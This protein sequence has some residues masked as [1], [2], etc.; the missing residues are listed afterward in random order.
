MNGFPWLT[1]AAIVLT[2]PSTPRLSKYTDSL[3][4]HWP[5]RISSDSLRA[6]PYRSLRA[7]T[8]TNDPLG[9]SLI[10]I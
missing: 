5:G 6:S 8:V 9:L 4:S 3:V 10:H 2:S 1:V 7:A